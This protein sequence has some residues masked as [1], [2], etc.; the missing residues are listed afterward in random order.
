MDQRTLARKHLALE[1]RPAERAEL[2]QK[3]VRYLVSSVHFQLCLVAIQVHYPALFQSTPVDRRDPSRHI[4]PAEPTIIQNYVAH[5]KVPP[6]HLPPRALIIPNCCKIPPS[7]LKI[8]ARLMLLDCTGC[9]HRLPLK[10]DW[11]RPS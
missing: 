10:P 4:V 9:K 1:R 2:Q 7:H 11:L 3:A 6:K 5:R 8:S